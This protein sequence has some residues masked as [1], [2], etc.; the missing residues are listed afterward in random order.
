L[1][2][3]RR[4]APYGGEFRQ[5]AGAIEAEKLKR[6]KVFSTIDN[7]IVAAVI[8]AAGT[9]IVSLSLVFLLFG[10]LGGP[11]GSIV[12]SSGLTGSWQRMLPSSTR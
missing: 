11:C 9:L 1:P 2:N 8:T 10:A 4:G 3:A 6:W 5:A 12:Q 7:Q